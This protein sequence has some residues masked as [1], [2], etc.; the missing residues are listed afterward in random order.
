[1]HVKETPFLSKTGFIIAT[2]YKIY[3]KS[4]YFGGQL[5]GFIRKRMNGGQTGG[6]IRV[7]I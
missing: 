7:Y 1:M 5:L 3:P 2:L 6:D 4:K